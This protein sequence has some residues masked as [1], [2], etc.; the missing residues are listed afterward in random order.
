MTG[1]KKKVGLNG[2]VP[3]LV[4][5]SHKGTVCKLKMR[6]RITVVGAVQAIRLSYPDK[7]SGTITYAF[8]T[9][10][11]SA[12]SSSPNDVA[13]KVGIGK[14]KYGTIQLPLFNEP[15]YV[16]SGES[17]AKTPGNALVIGNDNY[18]ESK[19]MGSYGSQNRKL[20]ECVKNANDIEKTLKSKGF[21]VT[22]L[23]DVT[24]QQI[25]KALNSATSSL[26]SETSFVFYFSGHGTFEGLIGTDGDPVS[27]NDL[28]QLVKEAIKVNSDLVILIEA[29]HSGFVVDLCRS[30][31]LDRAKEYNKNNAKTSAFI[32]AAMAVTSKKDTFQ[33]DAHELWKK[34]WLYTDMISNP[35]AKQ[36]EIEH[37]TKLYEQTYQE[38]AKVWNKFVDDVQPQINDAVQK[39]KTAGVKINGVE[40]KDLKLN[41][42]NAKVNFQLK[43]EKQMW[44]QLDSV[45]EIQNQAVYR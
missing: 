38:W 22:K 29:C 21:T 9:E 25:R 5:T 6:P 26:K 4:H 40:I 19:K 41:K 13:Q 12:K 44:A 37:A 32:K 33:K 27:P 16:D 2:K 15:A 42:F 43:H 34:L 7:L 31:L 36:K 3:A 17:V 11:G 30:V 45:D 28:S 39:G 8:V 24:G 20:T 1:D 18:D 14:H 23:T 35:K 10:Y